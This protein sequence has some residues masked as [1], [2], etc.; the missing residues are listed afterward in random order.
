M[1]ENREHV[2]C[3][4]LW[5]KNILGRTYSRYEIRKAGVCGMARKALQVLQKSWLDIS[6]TCNQKGNVRFADLPA[7][8]SSLSRIVFY[9]V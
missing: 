9:V 5:A 4:W 8:C 6:R 7:L 2:L 3:I 1:K